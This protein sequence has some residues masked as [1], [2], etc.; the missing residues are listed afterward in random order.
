MVVYRFTRFTND[1][2][3]LDTKKVCI[4]KPCK[5]ANQSKLLVSFKNLLVVENIMNMKYVLRNGIVQIILQGLRVAQ[6]A[7]TERWP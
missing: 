6:P 1:T 7:V 4:G 2:Y 5:P 3:S